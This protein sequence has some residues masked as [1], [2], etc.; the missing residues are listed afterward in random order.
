MVKYLLKIKLLVIGVLMTLNTINGQTYCFSAPQGYGAGTT[1]GNGGTVTTVT[2]QS[3][4]QSA[5][6]ASGSAV[7]LVSGTISCSYMSVLVSNKTLLGLPGAKL[8]N[9]GQTKESSGIM[10]I[11]SGSNNVIIRNLIF[12]G[13]GA[14][15]TDGR[16]LL[17]IDG[18]SKIWVDHCEFQDGCDGNYDHKGLT[19]NVTVSW[20]KFTYLKAPK[21]GG[22]GGTDDHRFT[23]LVGSN[24]T[25]KPSDG[26]YSITWQ[27]CWWAEGCVE[28]MT[29][30][31][32]A[33]L[34]MLNCYWNSSVAKV[35]LGLGGTTDCYVENSVFANTGDKYRYYNNGTVRFATTGCTNPPAPS[36]LDAA[37]SPSYTREALAAGSLVSAITSS[38][39]AGA[40]LNVT[41]SGVVSAK[42]SCGGDNKAPTVSITAPANNASYTA[43][44]SITINASA[45]DSDGNIAKVDFYNGATLLGSDNSSAYSYTWSNVAA[46]TYTIKVIATDNDGATAESTI[47]VTVSATPTCTATVTASGSTSFC[48]GGSVTLTASQGTAYVWK[49]GSNQVGTSQTYTANSSGSYTV[50]VTCSNGAKDVSDAVAVTVTGPTTWYADTDGDGVGD[51]NTTQVACSKPNG[52]VATSGDQCPNDVNKTSP[53]GCGCG[54]VEGNCSDC[55]GVANG[56]AI[57]DNCLRCVGGNTGLRECTASFQAETACAKEGTVDVDK[58]GFLGTGF[59]NTPNTVGVF[60][61][62]GIQANTAGNARLGFRYGNTG[63]ANRTASVTVNGNPTNASVNF[64]INASSPNYWTTEEL[65][66]ALQQ[67][68]N[69]V[70]LTA[71]TADGLPNLDFMYVVGSG[72]ATGSCEPLVTELQEESIDMNYL[73]YP[74]PSSGVFGLQTP[75]EAT[76]TVYNAEGQLVETIVSNGTVSFGGNY[77]TG[78]YLLKVAKAG[79]VHTVKI[80]KE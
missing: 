12:E 24:D 66:V 74:N 31:R 41:S 69:L 46:G 35:A 42:S 67:G 39:G 59:V 79:T 23:N 50:E 30:A 56:T 80:V 37:P 13:P 5:L 20:C 4:L 19:D 61:T 9:L 75:S 14:Y 8:V 53:G 72:Y 52:Y 11:K 64:V 16:D 55:A 36:G 38:C 68:E 21:S 32:N 57:I 73:L 7:I 25:D 51:A 71:T 2:S 62:F 10:N 76:I 58:T 70:K 65:E 29:R 3:T 54:K 49:N 48:Q 1:G 43:P 17:T 77:K 18:G 40:T 63:S 44:A 47:S 22:S 45:T 26:K 27:Y 60:V 33:Q 34:H 78:V 6:T 28:R 15:D